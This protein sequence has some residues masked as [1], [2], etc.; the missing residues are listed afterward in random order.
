AVLGA[1]DPAAGPRARQGGGGA[2]PQAGGRVTRRPAPTGRGGRG[3]EA[4]GRGVDGGVGDLPRT[5]TG[6]RVGPM[7]SK[8]E[9]MVAYLS[10]RQGAA[11]YSVRREL[12][13]PASEA[14]RWLE[15]LQSRSRGILGAGPSEIPD[16]IPARPDAERT[17]VSAKAEGRLPLL[18][19]G[20]SSAALVFLVAGAAWR[21]QDVR[22]RRL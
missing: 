8:L 13:D 17:I 9:M 16:P 3:P 5:P 6:G 4:A 15:A 12:A 20:A 11:A 1:G 14:S 10:G 7:K 18:L 2:G 19:L 22:L 21:S